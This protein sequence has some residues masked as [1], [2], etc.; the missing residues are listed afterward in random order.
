MGEVQGLIHVQPRLP[1]AEDKDDCLPVCHDPLRCL[2][3]SGN[4]GFIRLVMPPL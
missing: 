2:G 1:S 4:G 3:V